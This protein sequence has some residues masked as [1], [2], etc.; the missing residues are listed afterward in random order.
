MASFQA[1]AASVDLEPQPGCWLTGF[2]A[3]VYPS[4]GQHDPIKARA[5]LLD[6]GATQI[7][8]VACDLIG[9]SAQEIAAL[10]KRMAERSR[11]P[12]MNIVISCSHTH[13]APA[14][15]RFRGVLGYVNERWWMTAQDKLVALVASLEA[16]LRPAHLSHASTRV[17]GL[18]YNRQDQ[19]HPID[20]ELM[21]V[22]IDD[23]DGHA[24][25]TL[26]NF[27][28]H[29]VTMSFGNLKLS[30]DVPG[31]TAQ[32]L[33]VRRGGVALYLQGACG[34]VASSLMSVRALSGSSATAISIS[35]TVP[36]MLR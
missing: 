9:I 18:S 25:A 8:I 26:V 31:A 2:G 20:T 22:A 5:V 1:A 35:A 13:S 15:L 32:E 28:M 14:T 30:G 3:R 21:A 19:A 29:P 34:D 24:I 7:V 16:Q 36:R 4:D 10:R 11:T 12:A 6:D 27:A 23:V 17:E 33:E